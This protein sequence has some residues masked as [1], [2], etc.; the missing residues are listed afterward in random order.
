MKFLYLVDFLG[1]KPTLLV[2]KE[3]SHKSFLGGI[4]SLVTIAAIIC[5]LGYFGSIL[6]ARQTFSLVQN[7]ALDNS[8]TMS[9]TGTPIGVSIFSSKVIKFENPSRVYGVTLI[10]YKFRIC[11]FFY[12]FINFKF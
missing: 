9:V 6:F 4:L 2:A 11:G 12:I 8:M 10:N 3:S 1:K 7:E 5:G